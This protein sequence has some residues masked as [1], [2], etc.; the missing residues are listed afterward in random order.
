LQISD[1]IDGLCV[2]VMAD[3]DRHFYTS[4]LGKMLSALDENPTSL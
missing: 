3:L 2:S 4:P 1:I